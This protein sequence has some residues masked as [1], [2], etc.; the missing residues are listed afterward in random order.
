MVWKL[1]MDNGPPSARLGTLLAKYFN[2]V[3]SHREDAQMGWKYSAAVHHFDEVTD[4]W[5]ALNR[6]L[7]NHV[8]LDSRFVAA[9]LRR[10]GG[11]NVLLGRDKDSPSRGM[12]LLSRTGVGRWETFQPAQAPLGMFVG[13]RR[14]DPR[15]TLIELL[16]SL[17]GLALQVGVLQQDPDFSAFF[18]AS[19]SPQFEVLE[20]IR[21][22]RLSLVSTFE[23]YWNGRSKNLKHNL[24]RQRKRLTEQGRH[25][26][27]IS[28]R[29]PDTVADA[30]REYGRLE[31]QGWKGQA[32]TAVQESNSQGLFYREVLEAFCASGEGVIYQLLLDGKVIASDLCLSRSN[33]LVVLKTAYDESLQQVSAAL[34]MRQEILRQLYEEKTIQVVEFYGRVL[35]WHLKWTDQVRTMYHINCFRNRWVAKIRGV[36]KRFV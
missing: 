22:P 35:D 18:P 27:L 21:T 15:E 12:V 19:A 17:P 10:L 29:T 33:M 30:L 26:E 8:L 24:T 28:H 25:L 7:Y 11:N 16:S 4:Q 2:R 9:S 1:F 14:H 23:E 20:Y 36:A 5:D 32:G 3:Q 31:S 13:G 6:A 34:L